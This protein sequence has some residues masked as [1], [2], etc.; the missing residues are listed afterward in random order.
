MS[1]TTKRVLVVDDEP[2]MRT[3]IGQTL[4]GGGYAVDLAGDGA[5]ALER[6]RGAVPDAVVSDLDMPGMAG[7][8]L[9]RACR[10]DPRTAAVPI[11]LLSGRLTV[12]V[13]ARELGVDA[14]LA[15][16]FSPSRLL[17]VVDALVRPAPGGPGAAERA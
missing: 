12:D 2:A 11:V 6:L 15:K 9:V 1:D 7:A 3:L 14:W 17:A 13:V 4:A 10:A 8:A 5:A 16:P